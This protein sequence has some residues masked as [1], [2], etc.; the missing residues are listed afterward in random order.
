MGMRT[1]KQRGFTMIELM[2]VAAVAGILAAI[3][4]PSSVV[5]G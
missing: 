4:Y 3:A 1:E 5:S 2:I